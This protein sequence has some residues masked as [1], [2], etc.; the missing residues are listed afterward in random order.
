[1]ARRNNKNR[2]SNEDSRAE[3]K[4]L[5]GTL[6]QGVKALVD[7]DEWTNWLKFASVFHNYSFNNTM[8]IGIQCPG[9]THVAGYRTWQKLGRQVRKGEKGIRI[10]APNGRARFSKESKN[11]ETGEIETTEFSF[12]RFRAVSV[13]DI[14]QTDGEAAP[15]RPGI[16]RLTGDDNGLLDSLKAFAVAKGFSVTFRPVAGK[17]NGHI[18]LLTKSIVVDSTLEPAQQAKTLAHEIGHGLLHT[19]F[20]QEELG[21]D[22]KELEAESVAFI[23]CNHFGLETASYSFAYLACWKGQAA[24]KGLK[25]SATRITKA[26]SEVIEA[27]ENADKAPLSQAA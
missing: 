25:A 17:A 19:A 22:D 13:F 6:N 8:L 10:L 14:S 24:I 9:A 23:V 27:L 3:V 12:M 5:L 4:A 21:R 1:M 15:K 18:D 7:S 2:K 16:E 20:N 26:A 11:D